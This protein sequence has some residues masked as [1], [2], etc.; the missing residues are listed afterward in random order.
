MIKGISWN[1]NLDSIST[2]NALLKQLRSMWKKLTTTRDNLI[3]GEVGEKRV[4]DTM[5]N[6]GLNAE[7]I[8]KNVYMPANDGIG[9]TSETDILLVNKRGVFIFEVKNW[10]KKAMF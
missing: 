1:N 4:Y 5:I 6:L 2:L 8:R 9:K 7:K 3:K 10:G